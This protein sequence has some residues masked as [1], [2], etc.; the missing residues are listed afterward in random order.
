MLARCLLI[1]SVLSAASAFAGEPGSASD[2]TRVADD[3]TPDEGMGARLLGV[4]VAAGLAGVGA[5]AAGVGVTVLTIAIAVNRVDEVRPPAIQTDPRQWNTPTR[6][7]VLVGTGGAIAFALVTGALL[8]KSAC[9]M[10]KLACVLGLGT[11]ATAIIARHHG[12]IARFLRVKDPL[13]GSL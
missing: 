12:D 3:A 11:A 9:C 4:S 8:A 2:V 13:A 5:V 6:V 1:L 10:M 7:A